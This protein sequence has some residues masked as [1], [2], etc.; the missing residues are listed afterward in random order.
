MLTCRKKEWEREQTVKARFIGMKN[1]D[2]YKV[3]IKME[4][5]FF[6]ISKYRFWDKNLEITLDSF[7]LQTKNLQMWHGTE[8]RP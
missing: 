5:I 2:F 4:Y 8:T 7:I 3:W 6:K 1:Y